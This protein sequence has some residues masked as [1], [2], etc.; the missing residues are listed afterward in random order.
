MTI[1]NRQFQVTDP[2]AQQGLVQAQPLATLVVSHEGTLHVHD[3]RRKLGRSGGE[4]RARVH[5]QAR[6]KGGAAR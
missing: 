1:A 2:A 6:V 3:V 5:R 4:H